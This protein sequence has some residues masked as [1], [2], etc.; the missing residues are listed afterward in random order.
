MNN[1]V[2]NL[3]NCLRK[4]LSETNLDAEKARSELKQLLQKELAKKE[5]K[6]ACM[7]L[8]LKIF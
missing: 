6:F 4:T 3:L 8:C 1:A 2:K 5:V 7:D